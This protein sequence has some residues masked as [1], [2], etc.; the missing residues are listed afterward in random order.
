M[1]I[2]ATS[3]AEQ[4]KTTENFFFCTYVLVIAVTTV[5]ILL[6]GELSRHL[7]Q[8]FSLLNSNI[9]AVDRTLPHKLHRIHPLNEQRLR[10][11]EMVAKKIISIVHTHHHLSTTSRNLNRVFGFPVIVT[12]TVNF[13]IATMSL[14]YA[15]QLYSLP[16]TATS[17]AQLLVSLMWSTIMLI[18][19][20]IIC[21]NFQ[22]MADNVVSNLKVYTLRQTLCRRLKAPQS[23][24]TTC[25]IS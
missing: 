20:S 6:L 1:F 21:K 11:S 5:E 7:S 10:K 19:I 2:N 13:Q 3:F 14:Y 4:A 23:A 9:F 17:I 12:I 24:S 16:P 15:L 25:G 18:K 22:N 8:K